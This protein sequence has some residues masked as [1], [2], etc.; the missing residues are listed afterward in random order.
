[1]TTVP[2]QILPKA[3]YINELLNPFSSKWTFFFPDTWKKYKGVPFNAHNEKISRCRVPSCRNPRHRGDKKGSKTFYLLDDKIFNK[4]VGRDLVNG[5]NQRCQLSCS[6]NRWHRGE[7][8]RALKP[9]FLI[10]AW[11][12]KNGFYE[13]VCLSVCSRSCAA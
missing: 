11:V 2:V 6:G 13:S 12:R 4:I 5:K 9:I 3:F 7:N 1:M 10:T 8:H